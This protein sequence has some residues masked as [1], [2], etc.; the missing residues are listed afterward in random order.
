M[1]RRAGNLLLDLQ[2]DGRMLVIHEIVGNCGYR[3]LTPV[4]IREGI[5]DLAKDVNPPSIKAVVC[6]TARPRCLR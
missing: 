2:K 4:L 6:S 5:L 1:N 3:E